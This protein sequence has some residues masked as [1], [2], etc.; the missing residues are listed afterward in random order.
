MHTVNLF[1]Y[2]AK[3]FVRF[4]QQWVWFINYGNSNLSRKNK[5]LFLIN[6]QLTALYHFNNNNMKKQP[7]IHGIMERPY[8]IGF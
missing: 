7:F 8:I 2:L 5:S 6:D 4:I 1:D 3:T